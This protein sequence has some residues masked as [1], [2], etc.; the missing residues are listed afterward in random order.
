MNIVAI[1]GGDVAGETR[2]IDEVLVSLAGRPNPSALFIPTATGDD[3]SYVEK[4]TVAYEALG[5]SVE[6]LRLTRGD[7]PGK[8]EKADL[9][10]VGGGNTKAMI[11]LW[12]QDGV[13]KLLKAHLDQGKPVG[14]VSAGAICWFR[15]GNSD[16]PLYEN[17]PNVNTARLDAL[18]FVDLCLCPHTKREEFRM[19]EFRQM[20][21]GEQGAGVGVDDCCA[22][23]I[24]GEEYRILSTESG[25]VA[26]RIEWV[27]GKLVENELPPHDDFRPL[28]FLRDTAHWLA[29]HS[30]VG[31]GNP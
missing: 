26:H 27:Q 20:M 14:G 13:D 23:Q 28:S 4:F 11:A 8:I 10:Y 30:P 19:D 5:C 3:E 24:R 18:G 6:V 2:G 1:G 16:W 29:E 9:I 7:D 15:V 31:G 25:S 22:I 21:K 12:R 17:I